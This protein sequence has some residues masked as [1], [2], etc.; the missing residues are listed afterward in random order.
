[1][2]LPTIHPGHAFFAGSLPFCFSAYRSYQ[3][4]LDDILR[5]RLG[6][7]VPL[8]DL[9]GAEEAVRQAVGSA[10]AA[11]ALRVATL[12]SVGVFGLSCSLFFY[13]MGCS[14]T[15]QALSRTRKWAHERRRKLDKA[16]GIENRVDCDHPEVLAVK[17]MTEE[18][19]MKHISETYFPD[20][21]WGD[22]EGD[23]HQ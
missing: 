1:M 14:S 20:E 9:Q 10:V 22:E 8:R 13:A 21:E 16:L 4:P 12:G 15:E 11:R 5:A 3:K 6:N 7:K 2:N 23:T 18:D 17:G 19:E